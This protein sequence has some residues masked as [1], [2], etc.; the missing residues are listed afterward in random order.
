MPEDLPLANVKGPAGINLKSIEELAPRTTVILKNKTIRVHCD[1]RV[2]SLAKYLLVRLIKSELSLRAVMDARYGRNVHILLPKASA[3]LGHQFAARGLFGV[4]FVPIGK[5][6]RL[7]LKQTSFQ[8]LPIETHGDF[9]PP[10]DDTYIRTT[11]V[12]LMEKIADIMRGRSPLSIHSFTLTFDLGIAQYSVWQG[13][14]PT[15]HSASRDPSIR[16]CDG[17][18]IGHRQGVKQE[19][20]DLSLQVASRIVD[21]LRRNAVSVVESKEEI[22][23]H[24][25]HPD[26]GTVQVK[27]EIW[28]HTMQLFLVDISK[29]TITTRETAVLCNAHP[30]SEND[31]QVDYRWSL[32]VTTAVPPKVREEVKEFV[33]NWAWSTPEG[34]VVTEDLEKNGWTFK[35][36]PRFP[37]F[38]VIERTTYRDSF[39]FQG[40]VDVERHTAHYPHNNAFASRFEAGCMSHPSAFDL[41]ACSA[42]TFMRIGGTCLTHHRYSLVDLRGWKEC[43]IETQ[44]MCETLSSLAIKK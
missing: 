11:Y 41:R 12:S 14:M 21:Y 20:K 24:L 39:Y 26:H 8:T 32:R 43:I 38:T 40:N 34:F 16:N 33:K 30:R 15:I 7:S 10:T 22:L 25:Y 2:A 44:K 6:Y 19:F 23:C 35:H 42:K 1:Q 3:Q 17:L 9:H 27:F 31:L 18:L 28:P 37:S 4:H 36:A 29:T 5:G 13:K